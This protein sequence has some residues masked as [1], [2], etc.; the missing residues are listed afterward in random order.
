MTAEGVA[1][2][3]DQIPYFSEISSWISRLWVD[4]LAVGGGLV[5]MLLCSIMR[6]RAGISQLERAEKKAVAFSGQLLQC[7]FY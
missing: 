2:L 4:L 1:V 3:S 6:K 7:W 5:A